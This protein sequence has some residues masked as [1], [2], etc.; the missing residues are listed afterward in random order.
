LSD[1]VAK[2]K[3]SFNKRLGLAKAARY[4]EAVQYLDK[5]VKAFPDNVKIHCQIK[6]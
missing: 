5:I 4:S 3:E 6:A 1:D 2:A